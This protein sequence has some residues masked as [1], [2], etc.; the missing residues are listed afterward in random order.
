MTDKPITVTLPAATSRAL[1]T[2]AE[3][4]GRTPA[5]LAG[6]AIDRFVADEQAV[7]AK[8][9]AAVANADAGHVVPWEEALAGFHATIERAAARRRA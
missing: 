4:V 7:I 3:N 9:K 5:E 2:L 1:Q 6:A 8:I